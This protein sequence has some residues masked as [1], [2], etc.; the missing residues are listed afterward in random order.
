MKW[1]GEGFVLLST[2]A[3]AFSAALIKEY[4]RRE[5]TVVLSGLPVWPQAAW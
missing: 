3:Y 4:S 2:V 5:D 1:N